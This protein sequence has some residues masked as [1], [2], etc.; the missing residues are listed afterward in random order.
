MKEINIELN[1]FVEDLIERAIDLQELWADWV[2][3]NYIDE[4]QDK[5]STVIHFLEDY[6]EKQNK[7]DLK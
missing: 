5:Y 1:D 6:I 2:S 7:N 4:E 3:Q